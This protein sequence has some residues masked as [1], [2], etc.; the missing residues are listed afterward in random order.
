MIAIKKYK[1]SIEKYQIAFNK[2]INLNE[3]IS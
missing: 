3:L 1:I 2:K